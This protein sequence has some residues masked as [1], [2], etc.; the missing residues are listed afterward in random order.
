VL[1]YN[2]PSQCDIYFLHQFFTNEAL[3]QLLWHM[4]TVY[5][6]VEVIKAVR[7][8]SAIFIRYDANS[9]FS[10]RNAPQRG[11]GKVLVKQRTRYI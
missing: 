10:V 2:Q 3:Y 9:A 1:N 11:T 4:Y 5:L 6:T 8:G 7:T